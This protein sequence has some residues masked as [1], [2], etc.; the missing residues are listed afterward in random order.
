MTEPKK[1]PKTTPKK[2][3]AKKPATPKKTTS[4]KPTPTTNKS[5]TAKKT[6]S[7]TRKAAEPKKTSAKPTTTRKKKS[8]RVRKPTRANQLK[9]PKEKLK[10]FPYEMF[11]VRLFHME[12]KDFADLK[13]C[14][15]TDECYALKYIE[16][17]GLKKS[18]YKMVK[19]K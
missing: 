3:V 10:M 1:K 11:P 17:L 5:S 2:P 19:R 7:S 9:I 16:R 4:A 8:T 18:E 15:F 12:G 13:V 14:S 6:T